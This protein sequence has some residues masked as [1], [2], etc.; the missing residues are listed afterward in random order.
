MLRKLTF[1][2]IVAALVVGWAVP[3]W[4]HVTVAP[5]SA[6]KGATDQQITFR[7]PSEEDSPTTK[8]QINLPTDPP[9]VG[10][11]AEPVAGWKT[12][13]TTQHLSKPI[14]TDD[15]PVSDIVNQVTWTADNAASGV[16][17]DNFQGFNILAGSLPDSGDQVVFKAVQ[18]YANGTVV[19]WV[20]P[21]TEGGPEAEHPTPI[22][23]LT[24]GTGSAG[25]GQTTTTVATG[26]SAGSATKT[27]QDDA[28]T[29]KTIGIIAIIFSVLALIGVGIG[30]AMRRKPASR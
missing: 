24:A 5:A 19:N 30:F 16:Q 7:V 9:L 29:A 17:P 12:S 14:Q 28:D 10:V 4:A 20:D 11:L 8:V 13:V 18:T 22:L 6:S 3:A 27:A 23:T 25:G 1:G 2:G 26:G 21:V 15:G